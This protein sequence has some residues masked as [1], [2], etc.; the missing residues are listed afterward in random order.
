MTAERSS[1]FIICFSRAS[2][3]RSL[4]SM[5][6]PFRS[7][8]AVS[9]LQRVTCCAWAGAPV[10]GRECIKHN[11][12]G[13]HPDGLADT[14]FRGGLAAPGWCYV[15]RRRCSRRMWLDVVGLHGL[16][17]GLRRR[18]QLGVQGVVEAH[19][20]VNPLLGGLEACLLQQL[21]G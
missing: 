14:A 3:N 8:I 6:M 4:F 19:R 11:A 15:R 7:S 13:S 2:L 16:Q 12:K 18:A 10:P 5:E 21:S 17:G 9:L 20:G 1:A